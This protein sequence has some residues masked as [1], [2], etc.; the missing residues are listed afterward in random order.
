MLSNASIAYTHWLQPPAFG[1]EG[2]MRVGRPPTDRPRIGSHFQHV[3]RIEGSVPRDFADYHLRV[4]FHVRGALWRSQTHALCTSLRENPEHEV[5]M[6][7]GGTGAF[8]ARVWAFEPSARPS[9]RPLD[10][11]L[12]GGAMLS[13]LPP[14]SE[15]AARLQFAAR[16]L[17]KINVCQLRSGPLP[18]R[19]VGKSCNESVA[20]GARA[21]VTPDALMTSKVWGKVSGT[22]MATVD[23]RTIGATFVL[24]WL[25]L[26][27]PFTM[28][29]SGNF[30][31]GTTG[32][33][34][35]LKR[36]LCPSCP[37]LSLDPGAYRRKRHAAFSC[38]RDALDYAGLLDQVTFVEDASPVAVVEQPVGYTYMDGGKVRFCN[39][40][41]V[42]RAARGPL[43]NSRIPPA[44]SP[45]LL[46]PPL[47]NSCTAHL[48]RGQD[49]GRLRGGAG[50]RLAGERNGA[51]GGALRPDLDGGGASREWGLGAHASPSASQA[52]AQR[53][54]QHYQSSGGDGAHRS[55]RSGPQGQGT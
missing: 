54:A 11:Q 50:R 19:F 15:P 45:T 46:P 17:S 2:T 10:M 36:E 6:C 40:P 26:P 55:P 16:V 4:D 42:S 12:P 32:Y 49:D 7:E 51:L 18:D 1:F 38:N 47:R 27:Q 33:F 23:W 37:L 31:G 22:C 29:E 41:L 8:D 24:A 48:P 53:L 9:P 28:V 20:R 30:C 34:A 52:A 25:T 43:S 13:Q 44:D 39:M 3:L 35:L 21:H 5:R 14:A